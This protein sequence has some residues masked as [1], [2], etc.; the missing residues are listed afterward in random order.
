M[1]G[2]IGAV[3][4]VDISAPKEVQDPSGVGVGPERMATV[5]VVLAGKRAVQYAVMRVDVATSVS[6]TVEVNVPLG[7]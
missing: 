4:L 3:P 6:K 5:T 1:A 7:W 2:K